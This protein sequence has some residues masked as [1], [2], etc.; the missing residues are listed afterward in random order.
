MKEHQYENKNLQ[1][2]SLETEQ[3]TKLLLEANP[4]EITEDIFLSLEEFKKILKH[5]SKS[6]PGPDKIS[7]QLLKA[8][9]KNIKAFICIIIACSID[10]SY[11][12]CL[13]KGSQVTML[14]KPQKEGKKAE[15]YRPISLINCI[16]KVC[17]TV[18][19]NIILE[20]CEANKVLDHNK[21]HTEHIDAQPIIFLF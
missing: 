9:P 2:H 21:V 3:K 12:P 4:N 17:E 20:H 18:V 14:P 19:K 13:W 6:C 1:R 16:A 10:N 11:V 5:S 15:N 8:L 7:F